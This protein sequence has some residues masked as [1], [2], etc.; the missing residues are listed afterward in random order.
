MFSWGAPTT[1]DDI[2]KIV[3]GFFSPPKASKLR[4]KVLLRGSP[5]LSSYFKEGGGIAEGGT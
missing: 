3:S 4:N 1:L 2:R 5:S